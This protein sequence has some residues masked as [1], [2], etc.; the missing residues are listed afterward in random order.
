[1]P[2]GHITHGHHGAGALI[3]AQNRLWHFDGRVTRSLDQYQAGSVLVKA[4]REKCGISQRELAAKLA[5]AE[6]T[7][8]KWESGENR[9]KGLPLLAVAEMAR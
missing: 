9:L 8:R 3:V 4:V 7:V 5:V 2:A 6:I 1:M